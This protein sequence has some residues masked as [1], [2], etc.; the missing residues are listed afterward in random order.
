VRQIPELIA[1][2]ARRRILVRDSELHRQSLVLECRNIEASVARITRM[3]ALGRAVLPLVALLGALKSAL[4]PRRR[5]PGRS[6][7]S[8][9][10]AGGEAA[11][12][13]ASAWRVFSRGRAR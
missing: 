8:S 7:V 10:I 4:I 12:R 3:F 13:F 9:V 5:K 1:L 11:L 6:M 2:E